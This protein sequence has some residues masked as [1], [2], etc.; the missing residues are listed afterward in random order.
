MLETRASLRSAVRSDTV[1]SA[2]CWRPT[3]MMY[4]TCQDM[5]DAKPA[6]GIEASDPAGILASALSAERLLCAR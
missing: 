6:R 4:S 3:L 5:G 2:G 1:R